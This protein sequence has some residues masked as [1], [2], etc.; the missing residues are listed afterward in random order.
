MTPAD[1]ERAVCA[2]LIADGSSIAA[3]GLEVRLAQQLGYLKGSLQMIAD[4][5]P[6]SRGA[7]SKFS[8]AQRIAKRALASLE[9]ETS[10]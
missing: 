10:Q 2:L 1:L 4:L 5:E 9:Q 7:F 6:G 8:E 3:L